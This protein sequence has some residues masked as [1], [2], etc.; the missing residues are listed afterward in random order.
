MSSSKTDAKHE[1]ILINALGIFQVT[2]VNQ[3]PRNLLFTDLANT[4]N[5]QCR[6]Q[7]KREYFVTFFT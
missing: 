1:A 5:G 3:N 2:E 7:E 6:G 4:N